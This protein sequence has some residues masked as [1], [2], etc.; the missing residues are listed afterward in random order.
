MEYLFWGGLPMEPITAHVLKQ[1][2]TVWEEKTI[3]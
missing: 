1:F 3:P 2:K